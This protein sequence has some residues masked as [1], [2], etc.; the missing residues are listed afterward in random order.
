MSV[1]V[2]MSKW[3]VARILASFWDSRRRHRRVCRR[4][5]LYRGGR[6]CKWRRP[7][8]G[9]ARR[10]GGAIKVRAKNVAIGS[11]LGYSV[12]IAE[13]QS[14][15]WI[16]VFNLTGSLPRLIVMSS[17]RCRT[18]DA[19]HSGIRLYWVGDQRL[20]MAVKPCRTSSLSMFT[21]E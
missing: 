21:A 1:L 10:S 6:G 5:S 14:D 8:V 16:G 11:A 7:T 2:M 3:P 20:R 18:R 15:S 9:K 19:S 12:E 17:S 13:L 4:F